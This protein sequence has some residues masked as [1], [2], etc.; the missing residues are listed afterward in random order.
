MLLQMKTMLPPEQY[1]YVRGVIKDGK[2]VSNKREAEMMVLLLSRNLIPVMLEEMR[3][4]VREKIVI[5]PEVAEELG[6]DLTGET[7]D[8]KPKVTFRK[9]VTERLK[10]LLGFMNIVH[11]MEK[12]SDEGSDNRQKPIFE[13]YAR[14]GIDGGRLR[15]LIGFEAISVGGSADI[16]GRPALVSGTVSDQ[17]PERQINVSDSEQGEAGGVLVV[18]VDRNDTRGDDPQELQGEYSFDW[19]EGSEGE[20]AKW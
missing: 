4:E 3:G 15:A 2:A 11:Q 5:D 6:I 8:A 10:V 17:L 18:S 16:D 19:G 14:R 9:D 20:T 13:V 7:T 1:E 12:R